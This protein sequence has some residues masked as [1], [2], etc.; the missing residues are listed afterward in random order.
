MKDEELVQ[1]VKS[2]FQAGK[3]FAAIQTELLTTYGKNKGEANRLLNL[4]KVEL[5]MSDE[6]F[7]LLVAACG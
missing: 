2:S 1:I 5:G 6:L 7:L 4:A 3:S